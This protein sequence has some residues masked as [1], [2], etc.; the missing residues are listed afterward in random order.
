[1][2]A[3]HTEKIKPARHDILLVYFDGCGW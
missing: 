3:I 2:K 1:M